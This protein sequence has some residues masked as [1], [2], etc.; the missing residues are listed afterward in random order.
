MDPC[1]LRVRRVAFVDLQPWKTSCGSVQTSWSPIT[2]GVFLLI[3]I[4]G[5]KADDP[6]QIEIK[7]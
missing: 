3:P 5:K 6:S 2:K 7:R 4:H 1:K